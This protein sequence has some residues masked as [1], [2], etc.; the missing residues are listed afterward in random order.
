M[1]F[2]SWTCEIC[3]FEFIR[4]GRGGGL[5]DHE[6]F[7]EGGRKL[8]RFETSGVTSRERTPYGAQIS[9]L[10]GCDATVV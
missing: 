4:L 3:L 7:Y 8:K 5:E 2:I 1:L 9:G 10:H 6:T